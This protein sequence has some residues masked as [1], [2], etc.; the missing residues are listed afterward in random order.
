MCRGGGTSPSFYERE[1]H[2]VEMWRPFLKAG[3]ESNEVCVWVI[4]ETLTEKGRLACVGRCVPGLDRF[5]ADRRIE[6]LRS[7]TWYVTGDTLIS[8][9]APSHRAL[10]RTGG[11]QLGCGRELRSQRA[12][13]RAP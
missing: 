10:V 4:P 2:L 1:E 13:D 6:T 11:S 3:L 7:Q 12:V 8:S 9:A 5:R